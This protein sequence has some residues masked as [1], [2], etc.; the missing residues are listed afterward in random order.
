MGFIQMAAFLAGAIGK[1]P[2]CGDHQLS[3]PA[4]MGLDAKVT[5]LGCGH[6]A[7]VEQAI[8]AGKAKLEPGG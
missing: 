8:D 5:C 4:N 3:R 1:C 2:K 7:T 6:V